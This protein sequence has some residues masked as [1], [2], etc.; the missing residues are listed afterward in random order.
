MFLVNKFVTVG[1]KSIKPALYDYYDADLL[2]VAKFQLMN[3]IDDM[4]LPVKRQHVPQHRDGTAWLM[5]EVDDVVS[6]MTF[7]DE[8]KAINN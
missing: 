1:V 8:Q 3:D 2:S 7:L 5:R 4:N 6:L